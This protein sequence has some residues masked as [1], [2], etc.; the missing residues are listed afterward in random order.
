VHLKPDAMSRVSI[1]SKTFA[2]MASGRPLLMAVEGEAAR[3]VKQHS[4][5]LAVAPSDPEKLADV[6]REFRLLPAAEQQRMGSAGRSAYLANY[7]SPVQIAKFEELLKQVITSKTTQRIDQRSFYRRR[8]KRIFDL[9]LVIPALL[10]LSPVMLVLA[11]I[12]RA[13]LGSPV[14][15]R[16][17]RPGCHARHFKLIKFR[18]MVDARDAQGTL[19]PDEQRLT[20]FGKFLRSSSL[21]E[22]PELWNILRGDMSFVGPRPLL[23]EYLPL[24]TPEQARR[25]DVLPGLTGWSQIHGRNAISWEKKFE[26][27]TWYVDNLSP[28]IDLKILGRTAWEVLR[29]D[30]ISKQGF[31]TTDLFTGSL[32][33]RPRIGFAGDRDIAVKV[34]EYLLAEGT[35]PELLLVAA[36]DRA[37][38]AEALAE[39]CQYLSDERVMRGPSFRDP[40]NI[41]MIRALDLDYIISIHFPYVYPDEL[42]DVARGGIINLHPSFLPFGRG[43]HTPSW[44]ILEECPFGATLHV[45]DKGVDTGEILHQLQLAVEPDDTAHSLYQRVKPLELE[46]FRQAWPLLREGR[47]ARQNQNDDTAARK[48][49]DLLSPE[50][51]RIDLDA[52]TTAR[53]LLQR[54]RALTTDRFEEAAYFEEAGERYRV[55][56]EFS[57]DTCAVLESVATTTN[58]KIA[59]SSN[60]P[61]GAWPEF[62]EEMLEAASRVLRSGKVNYWTGNEG[63]EF[64]REYAEFVGCEHAIALANGTVALEL[65]LYSLGIGAGD[66]VIVPSRTF[67]ATASS[68]VARGARPVCADVDRDSQTITADT[69]AP[70]I[71]P[72]TKAIIPVHLAGWSC[73]MVPILELAESHGL[74]VIEDCAQAH[75]A[76]YR[77]RP[78]GSWGDMGAFSFCQDKIITTAG[79]GGM[80]VTNNA[81]L[82]KKAW[83]YK[84]HGKSPD[85][86][87][88]PAPPSHQFRWLHE[89]FGSN[90][91]LIEVSAAIGRIMLRRLPAWSEKRREHARRL[92]EACQQCPGL[93][94][95]NPGPG[96]LH[97]YY[98]FYTFV[99]PERLAAGW[100][101]DRIIQ[102]IREQ[103]VPC[104]SGSCSEIYLEQAFPL[105][106][107]PATRHAVAQEL[108]ET[109]LMFLVH[110]TL[111]DK[112]IHTTCQAIERVLASATQNPA[113]LAA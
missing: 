57:R 34:L 55:R 16:Q 37:S 26:F 39:R 20:A 68:V 87:Y 5:G 56:V 30:G 103:G 99:R 59:P 14:L 92:S 61:F 97:G 24:Y 11:A 22:L 41:E 72:R 36:P 47:L 112:D 6:I 38:H 25:H 12:I 50:I 60:Q 45:V 46:V 21:D 111:A 40:A 33:K 93:R 2:C 82:W 54:M 62:D 42:L 81:E 13:K 9:L 88:Q 18:S 19:L 69:I 102:A 109:S 74:A 98:K 8:G 66:E 94:T 85:A 3:L 90:Y 77:G 84:D 29:R 58:L 35:Q 70:L 95:P 10:I 44:A 31:A 49:R 78:V 53:S 110:P 83:R 105:D 7:S 106:W 48:R 23:R 1:P 63:R 89:E 43:W 91:R 76:E 73:D 100:S 101:R 32:Q 86:F 28:W 64:E 80:L 67:I 15:F 79:E 52:T 108:G 107:R 104:F 75:G 4:C 96:V 65:A 27:D 71:T 17:T 113:R 51:Q